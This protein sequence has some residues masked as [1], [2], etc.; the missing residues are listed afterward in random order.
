MNIPNSIKAAL[1]VAT[2]SGAVFAQEA[3]TGSVPAASGDIDKVG[4]AKNISK[5]NCQYDLCS[6]AVRV[7]S[8]RG[9]ESRWLRANLV[10]S[11]S[12]AI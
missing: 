11:A 5:P 7:Q 6:I 3:K 4:I 12:D 2:L 8:W 9:K 1:L 10:V